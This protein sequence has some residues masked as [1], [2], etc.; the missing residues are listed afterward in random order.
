MSNNFAVTELLKQRQRLVDE[1]TK[2]AERYQ[3]EISEMERA[4]QLLTGNKEWETNSETLY[5]DNHP[6]YIKASA[7]EI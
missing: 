4:I 1:Q 2:M 5:D 7:E 6:D 3:F